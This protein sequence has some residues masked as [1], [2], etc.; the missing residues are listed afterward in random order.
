M[1]PVDHVRLDRPSSPRWAPLHTRTRPASRYLNIQCARSS[2]ALIHFTSPR[3]PTS[4]DTASS[5][6]TSSVLL[7]SIS[8]SGT[9]FSLLLS[10]HYHRQNISLEKHL[11]GTF[12][13]H[14]THTTS[15]FFLSQYLT[16]LHLTTPLCVLLLLSNWAARSFFSLYSF[17]WTGLSGGQWI[18][19]WITPTTR[20]IFLIK[21]PTL[22]AG[23]PQASWTQSLCPASCF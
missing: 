6:F 3:V 21:Q 18:N 19:L 14:Q 4:S 13:R 7:A 2:L 9:S 20:Y 15:F 1:A 22:S 12:L 11:Y 17:Q 23:S 16:N 5:I 10:S 8:V